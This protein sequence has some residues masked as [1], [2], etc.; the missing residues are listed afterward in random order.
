MI[1]SWDVCLRTLKIV[2]QPQA[3]TLLLL[4]AVAYSVVFNPVRTF[5]VWVSNQTTLQVPEW[6]LSPGPFERRAFTSSFSWD[7]IVDKQSLWTCFLRGVWIY[8]DS[9]PWIFTFVTSGPDVGYWA[10]SVP[11]Y[12]HFVKLMTQVN[13]RERH[14]GPRQISSTSGKH[15][16][17]P[18]MWR[19]SQLGFTLWWTSAERTHVSTSSLGFS[20][21]KEY[22]RGSETKI[23]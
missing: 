6:R 22:K 20:A 8:T 23:V 19:S 13:V 1:H 17:F 16:C 18:T 21:Y 2:T 11:Q 7:T 15:T 5:L 4:C 9:C 14:T 12:T 10:L 3:W